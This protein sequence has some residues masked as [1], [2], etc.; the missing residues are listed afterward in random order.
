MMV[1]AVVVVVVV[2]AVVVVCGWWCVG[3]AM[4]GGNGREM[5]IERSFPKTVDVDRWR[6]LATVSR[7]C[8]TA[9]QP[10]QRSTV[11]KRSETVVFQFASASPTRPEHFEAHEVTSGCQDNANDI[12]CGTGAKIS[13]TQFGAGLLSEMIRYFISDFVAGS[14]FS[15]ARIVLSEVEIVV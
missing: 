5:E 1:V 10:V 14:A 2:V 13:L 15:V 4:G 11:L 7:N 9:H 6:P 12:E 8:K 3:G